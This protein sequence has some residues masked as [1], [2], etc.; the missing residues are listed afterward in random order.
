MKRI[1]KIIVYCLVISLI[2]S[3]TFFSYTFAETNSDNKCPACK[4]TPNEMQMYI[5]FEVEL[6]WVL[7]WSSEEKQAFWTNKNSWLF[8]WWGLSLPKAF[9]K[10]TLS[11]L[12]KSFESEIQATRA[13]TIAAVLLE[14]MALTWTGDSAWALS[15]LFKDE[16]FVRDYK[17]LQEIDMSINDVIR[18][19][20]TLGIWKKQVSSSI[21]QDILSL[22]IKYSKDYWWSIPIFDKLI[23]S[24]SVKNRELLAF[25]LELNSMIKQ[26]LLNVWEGTPIVDQ[27]ISYFEEKY[28]KWNIIAT[29]NHT[30]ESNIINAYSC[31]KTTTC[32][33]SLISALTGMIAR[34][35]FQQSFEDAKQTI[36]DAN[37]TLKESIWSWWDYDWVGGRLT[38]KKKSDSIWLTDRQIELLYSVYW[39]DAY[40]LNTSQIETWKNNFS[41][42]KQDAEPLT[43]AISD[44]ADY[45]VDARNYTKNVTKG[46]WK[47]TVLGAKQ[48]RKRILN[49]LGLWDQQKKKVDE[50]LTDDEKQQ[51][52]ETIYWQQFL[53]PDEETERWIEEMTNTV[54]WILVQKAKDKSIITIWQSQETHYFVEIGSYIR[55]IVQE[56]IWNKDKWLIKSLWEICTYQCSNHGTRNCYAK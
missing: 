47:K 1:S 48:A 32:N 9:Y 42:M 4:S 18:D 27:Y 51:K 14:K 11:K 41:Q 37:K 55:Q 19:M 17:I 24:T 2:I 10:S 54:N 39:I 44:A 12:K 25:L 23:I 5:N 46:L 43:S 7:R 6:L 13:V 50:A 30:Y 45:A 29:V 28:S 20:W 31:A 8:N 56:Q 21:Q 52:L 16:S 34:W 53:K 3:N 36:K 40:E 49:I 22:Q 15:I 35:D 38:K 26:I 33:G